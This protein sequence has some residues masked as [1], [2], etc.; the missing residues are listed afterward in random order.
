MP[1]TV[2]ADPDRIRHAIASVI[3]KAIEA[4]PYE[5]V[6]IFVRDS[7]QHGVVEV[8]TRG[9]LIESDLEPARL[10]VEALGG[11]LCSWRRTADAGWSSHCRR[12]MRPARAEPRG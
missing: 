9:T 11:K 3:A 7:M 8:R 10:L 2:R 1:V 6:E 5:Q 4:S 12:P